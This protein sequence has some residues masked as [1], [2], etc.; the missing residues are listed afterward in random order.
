MM[1]NSCL[2]GVRDPWGFRPLC[3]GKLG[4]AWCLASET[5]AFDLVGARFIRDIDPGRLFS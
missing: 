4:D 5:C 2:I 3:L 1:D